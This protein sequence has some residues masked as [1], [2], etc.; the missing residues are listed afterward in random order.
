[1]IGRPAS[2][3]SPAEQP[4]LSVQGLSIGFPTRSE[5]VA[6]AADEV[7]FEVQAGHTLGLVGESGCGKSV[8]LRALIGLVAYPGQVVGGSAKLEGRELLGLSQHEWER[9]RG[10]KV[11][12]IF[13]DPM[14]SLNPIYTVGNQLCEVLRLKRGLRR[15]EARSEAVRLLDHVGIRAAAS[16]LRDYPHQL[17]GGMRQRVMIAIAIAARP[18]L[19]LADEPTTALDVTVQDQILALIAELRQQMNMGTILVSHDLSVVAQVC[20]EIAVM[21]AGRVVERGP[22]D[23]VLENPQHPYTEGLAEAVAQLQGAHA[24]GRRALKTLGGQPPSLSDLPPGCSFAPR[25]RYRQPECEQFD[26]HLQRSTATQLT[27]CL[28][29]Q[30]QPRPRAGVGDEREAVL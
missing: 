28:I 19:L 8:T 22:V 25:C 17:S 2:E 27:A 9:V 5:A 4:L 15:E 21:Y 12:M 30:R 24:N 16:R 14:S 10:S 3:S 11:A 7:S 26:M 18:R 13:Q 1:M 29:R 6:M 20:D 23:D